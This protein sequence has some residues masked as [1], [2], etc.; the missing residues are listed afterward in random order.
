MR[1]REH[2]L[3]LVFIRKFAST[4]YEGF[5][6]PFEGLSK[7]RS[8]RAAI[9]HL[10]SQVFAETI[11]VL[12][13]VG[14]DFDFYTLC[15]RKRII[16]IAAKKGYLDI[17][18]HLL[19][20][21]VTLTEDTLPCAIVSGNEELVRFLLQRGARIDVISRGGSHLYLQQSALV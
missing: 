18:K 5:S 1:Q 15:S 2:A 8:F 21:N 6:S 7:S 10:D 13:G 9:K 14:A 4:A 16:D 3:V 20:K 17:V 12:E 19:C 11:E